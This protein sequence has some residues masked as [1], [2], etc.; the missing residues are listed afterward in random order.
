MGDVGIDSLHQLF[1][2]A[3]G[4]AADGLLSDD[5]QPAFELIEVA[6]VSGCE[7][8]VAARMTREPSLDPVRFMRAVVLRNEVDVQVRPSTRIRDYF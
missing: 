3:Q 6:G 5:P 1:D 7:R 2:P 4:A 8:N